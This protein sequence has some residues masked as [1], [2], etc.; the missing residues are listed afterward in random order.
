MRG[1][2]SRV[3]LLRRGERIT[4]TPRHRPGHPSESHARAVSAATHVVSRLEAHLH[5][6]T[7]QSWIQH[8]ERL[9]QTGPERGVLGLDVADIEH[10]EQIHLTREL[11]LA[12]LEEL[13]KSNIHLVLPAVV[14]LPR[15]HEVED[16]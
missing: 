7:E 14:R 6:Q 11:I 8:I 3:G 9:A 16:Q 13:P 10:V 2:L 15:R 5:G 12:H 4:R 1:S